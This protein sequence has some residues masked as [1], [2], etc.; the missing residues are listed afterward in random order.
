MVTMNI[1][2]IFAF[3]GKQTLTIEQLNQQ[4]ADLLKEIKK[5]QEEKEQQNASRS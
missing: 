2:E 3:I 5:L 4:I 1:E